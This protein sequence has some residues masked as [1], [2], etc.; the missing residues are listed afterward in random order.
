[1]NL[2][3]ILWIALT[4]RRALRPLLSSDDF[5]PNSL[6]IIHIMPEAQTRCVARKPSPRLHRYPKVISRPLRFCHVSTS[7]PQATP[8]SPYITTPSS[9]SF[10]LPPPPHTHRHRTALLV[11]SPSMAATSAALSSAALGTP[12]ARRR[13]SLATA[14]PR[15]GRSLFGVAGSRGGRV[16]AMA[17]YTVKLITPQ[18][19]FSI[20]CPDDVYI[21]DQAEEE[22]ISLPYS[23]RAGSCSSC[24][25]KVIEGSVDQSDGSFL[26]DD[27]ISAGFALT[28]VAYPTGNVVIETHKEEELTN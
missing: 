10:Q 7:P 1:M 11:S 25:G 20:E 21:L 2:S 9:S 3:R 4:M 5:A 23:C 15:C 6:V 26:D 14:L 16:Y 13:V 8:R 24:A 27:Q 22:G 19:E 28:C 18:G 12:F 17:S